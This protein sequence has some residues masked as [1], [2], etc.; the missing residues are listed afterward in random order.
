MYDWVLLTCAYS[1][2]QICDGFDSRLTGF[3]LNSLI[4]IWCKLKMVQLQCKKLHPD[5]TLPAKAGPLEMGWDFCCIADEEFYTLVEGWQCSTTEK[6]LGID[7]PYRDVSSFNVGDKIYFLYGNNHRHIFHTGLSCAV[8]P[9]YGIL[10]RDRSSM[11]AKRG[12]H[13]LAG[14]FD[15]T[16]RGEYMFPLVNLSGQLH[17]IKAGDKIVQGI[18]TRVVSGCASWVDNLPESE[19]GIAG[20]GEFS[21]R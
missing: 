4:L 13:V 17:I 19:R 5:A 3:L 14:V 10:M 7:Y 15:S 2:T 16:Y 6:L 11:G 20:F 8:D 21:G 9:G 1:Y 18:L 12:I